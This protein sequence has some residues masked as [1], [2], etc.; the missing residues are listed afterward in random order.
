MKVRPYD[1]ASVFPLTLPLLVEK[2]RI[3]GAGGYIEYGRVNGMFFTSGGRTMLNLEQEILPFPVLL[4]IS[5]L[6]RT[7]LCPLKLK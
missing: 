6:K 1:E 2:A 3:S 7:I 5:S 4:E